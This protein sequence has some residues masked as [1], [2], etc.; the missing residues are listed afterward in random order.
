MNKKIIFSFLLITVAIL[1]SQ[2]LPPQAIHAAPIIT[3][4]KTNTTKDIS[5]LPVEKWSNLRETYVSGVFCQIV[6]DYGQY[7]RQ[8]HYYYNTKTQ[9]M[10]EIPNMYF[11]KDV[12]QLGNQK[13]DFLKYGAKTN[14]FNYKGKKYT[15]GKD[16]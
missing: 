4:R 7:R 6:D 14:T 5:K 1:F 10:I 13:D 16:N 11:I 3:F 8:K 12:S 9:Q 2:I 15:I